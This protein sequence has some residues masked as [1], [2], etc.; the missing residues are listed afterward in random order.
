MPVRNPST[1]TFHINRLAVRAFCRKWHIAEMRLFG[2]AL[3][4]DFTDESDVDVLVSYEKGKYLSLFQ[5]QQA[6]N[7][8]SK[9]LGREVDWLN[10]NATLGNMPEHIRDE[11]LATAEVIHSAG[12]TTDTE[13]MDRTPLR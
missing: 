3:R 10:I 13:R 11:I 1:P 9:L 7:E 8:L 5:R 4:D 12:D 2:S 6:Q